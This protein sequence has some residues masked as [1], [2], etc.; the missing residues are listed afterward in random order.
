M[1]SDVS[2]QNALAIK[3]NGRI[4]CLWPLDGEWA[5]LFFVLLVCVTRFQ[6]DSRMTGG[7]SS[8]S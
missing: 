2:S 8:V 1:I 3:K 5:L 7:V 6:C 4:F